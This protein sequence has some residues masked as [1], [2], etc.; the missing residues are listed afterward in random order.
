MGRKVYKWAQSPQFLVGPAQIRTSPNLGQSSNLVWN[1]DIE[2]GFLPQEG[3]GRPLR[4]SA[5]PP[6]FGPKTIEQLA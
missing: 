1:I 6:K 5:P 4:Q 3:R 2:S